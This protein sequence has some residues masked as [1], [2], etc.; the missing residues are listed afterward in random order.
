MFEAHQRV[1]ELVEAIEL[2]LEEEEA[3]FIVSDRGG[4]A[5][6]SAG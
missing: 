2:P 6:S 4:G 3:M 1:T 5:W